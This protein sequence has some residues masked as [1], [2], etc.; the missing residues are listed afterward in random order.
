MQI[1]ATIMESSMGILREW[2]IDLSYDTVIP[3]L[4]IH[5]KYMKIAQ[6]RHT[7]IPMCIE[8]Q[9]TTADCGVKLGFISDS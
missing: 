4:R 7:K 8:A 6:E 1:G 3:C 5:P 9:T 2:K